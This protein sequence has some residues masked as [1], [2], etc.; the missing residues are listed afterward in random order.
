MKDGKNVTIVM[1][2]LSAVVLS[3]LLLGQLPVEVQVLP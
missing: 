1:L 2:L 3:V